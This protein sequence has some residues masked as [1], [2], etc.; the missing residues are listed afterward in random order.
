MINAAHCE[1]FPEIRALYDGN[2]PAQVDPL[3]DRLAKIPQS[4]YG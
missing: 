4:W 3:L 2:D 1:A